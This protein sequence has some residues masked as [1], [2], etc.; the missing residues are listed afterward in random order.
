MLEKVE[1]VGFMRAEFARATLFRRWQLFLQFGVAIPAGVSVFVSADQPTYYLALGGFLLLVFWLAAD[2]CSHRHRDSAEAARRALLLW[3]GLG[4]RPSASAL[5]DLRQ[6]FSVS[7]AQGQAAQDPNYYASEQPPGPARLAEIIEES[8]FWT[9]DLQSGSG[10]LMLAVFGGLTAAI[11][12]VAAIVLPAAPNVLLTVARLFLVFLV[13]G[14]SADVWGTCTGHFAAA[15]NIRAIQCRVQAAGLKQFPEA[16]V[17]LATADYNAAVEGAP[18]QAPVIY[19]LRGS[20]LNAL[21][22]AY[23]QARIEERQA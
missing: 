18:M 10:W 9:A 2:W 17:L 1:L 21:W 20:A 15:R 7:D 11:V 23:R 22:Q 4:Q 13:F 5:L 14:L 3:D 16:D 12:I 8:A 19:R 6:A